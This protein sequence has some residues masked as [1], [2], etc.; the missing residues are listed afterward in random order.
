MFRPLLAQACL[1]LFFCLGQSADAQTPFTSGSDF[2]ISSNTEDQ[3]DPRSG[4]DDDGNFVV[5]FEKAV[6][7]VPGLDIMGR[8]FASDGSPIGVDFQINTFTPSDQVYPNIAMQP[9]GEFVVVW[10]SRYQDGDDF[11]VFAQRFDSAAVP[12]GSEMAV[13]STTAGYQGNIDVAYGADDGFVVIWEHRTGTLSQDDVLGQRYDSAGSPLGGE[14]VLNTTTASDQNDPRIAVRP[15]GSFVAAWESLGQ[16]ADG[17]TVMVQLLASDLSPIGAEIQ[18]NVYTTNNQE[19]PE[20]AVSADGSFAVVWES[21]SQLLSGE[22]AVGR[23]FNSDGTPRSDE[24]ILATNTALDQENPEVAAAEDG[25][26]V[27]LWRHYSTTDL[28]FF[29]VQSQRL[30]SNGLKIG[31]EFTVNEVSD[32]DQFHSH[33]APMPGGRFIVSWRED[34]YPCCDGPRVKGRFVDIP[35]FADGFESG[36]T[37]AWTDR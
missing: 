37:T 3:F 19:D 6:Y 33:I 4:V 14:L 31:D 1:L 29:E 22:E 10:Q 7:G 2:Q 18:A 9:S 23:I 15:D 20:L 13:N 11:G 12:V 32:G 5:V 26:F 36:D 8:R 16:D 34:A 35:L 30:D 24:I 27:A 25:G 28:A 17:E 21:Q